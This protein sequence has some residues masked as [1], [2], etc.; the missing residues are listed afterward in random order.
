M[1]P[2]VNDKRVV[3][4][5]EDIPRR[6]Y[7]ILPDLP[8][9]LAPPL[10]GQ[11]KEP[12]KPEELAV[13]FPRA[14]LEQEMSTERYID[15]PEEVREKYIILNR[16]S[17]LQRAF[18]LEK[19]LKT[20]AKI[21][22][23][24]ED[25]S[26]TGS[27]KTNTS[28]PQA[29]YNMKEGIE[30]L[31][32]ETGAGQWGSALALACNMY[33]MQCEVYMVRISF[34]QKPYRRNV[35]ETYGATV[36]PSPST[37]TEAGRKI[38]EKDPDT[39]GS[40]GMAISEAVEMAV[41]DDKTNYSLGSVLNHVMLHQ[42]VIG[43][44]TI[45]QLELLDITP[46]YMIGCTGGGSNF[47]GF[48]FPMIGKKLK[49]E[50]DT[51]IIAVEPS[52]VPSLSAGKFEYDYGDTAGYTPLLMMYT[53]GHNFVPPSIHAGGLRYHGMA[54]TVSLLTKTGVVKP[55]TYNQTETFDAG[56]LFARTEGVIPAPESNH[57]IK[58]A[59]DKALEAKKNDEE[60]VIVFNLSG[61][62]L[63]DL[64]GYD[65]YLNGKLNGNS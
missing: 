5:I 32:T 3:L 35:M 7:N 46:D 9:P 57:A 52:S 11:T 34:D 12:I 30:R 63:L 31:T 58:A 42:T 49:G 1:T 54:P 48:T 33:D 43:E 20:P 4:G 19:A 44:E 37:R 38:L 39:P 45:K 10:N 53:L 56:V 55:V 2:L 8:E 64:T 36:Y 21:Y 25:L 47:A 60:K 50:V 51:E 62:G 16:P 61:H 41:K 23:K 17:P 24:R 59:I 26:P 29:Y 22:F 13:I 40:L 14:L 27:H 6:W 28:V 15:I 18:N 65:K